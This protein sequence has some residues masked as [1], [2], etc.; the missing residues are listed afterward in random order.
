[1]K[2]LTSFLPIF[3]GL[4]PFLIKAQ[5]ENLR[6]FGLWLGAGPQA[7]IL[8]FRSTLIIPTGL[9]DSVLENGVQAFWPGLEPSRANSVFQNVITNGDAVGEWSQLPF[10]CCK[11]GTVSPGSRQQS[12]VHDL[13]PGDRVTNTFTLN[14]N[15]LKW[16]NTYTITP[17]AV[18]N[19]AGQ[20]IYSNG[21]DFDPNTVAADNTTLGEQYTAA[22]MTI[23][24]QGNGN[25]N[26]GAVE[27]RDIL[28][29]SNTTETSWCTTGPLLNGG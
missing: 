23:E 17:G 20:K 13:Y 7:N 1:M 25:W 27:W 3:V 21:F 28:H 16:Y 15:T 5:I 10:Y 22:L 6:F 4:V 8:E 11:H 18:G 2:I 14:E 9:P 12:A 24:L 29:R 26:W 19:T